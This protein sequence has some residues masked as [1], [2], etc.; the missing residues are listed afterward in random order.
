MKIIAD[1]GSTGVKWALLT[2]SDNVVT[3]TT[4]G[5]NPAVM[6]S[7]DIRRAI[8]PGLSNTIKNINERATSV[9][10]YGA[11]CLPG[12]PTDKM[13]R[14]LAE[15][16]GAESIVVESDMLGACRALLGDSAGIVAILGTGSNS[17]YYNGEKIVANTIAGGYI[18]GDELSGA[19]LGKQLVGDWLKG[20]LPGDLAAEI[21]SLGHTP[22]SIIQ[23]VYR[24]TPDADMSPNRFLASF[25]PLYS[26]HRGNPWVEGTLRRGVKEFVERNIM[27]YMPLTDDIYPAVN[28]IGSVAEAFT[29]LLTKELPKL[30]F[31]L[32]RVVKT[33]LPELVRTYHNR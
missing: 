8:E 33:A 9:E 5:V 10:Y 15:I 4:A 20:I 18:L 3:F 31:S 29:D 30:K 28:F 6:G 13:R 2:D 1:G 24:S 16:T 21:E 25:A 32:G 23:K 7:E 11:G 12:E 14:L 26:T 27:A 17:C 19:W 22:R